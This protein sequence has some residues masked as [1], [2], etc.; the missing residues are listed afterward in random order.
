MK[1]STREEKPGNPDYS[2]SGRST[3][4]NPKQYPNY[5]KIFGYVVVGIV[6]GILIIKGFVC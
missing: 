1:K 2:G 4:S 6:L 3:P 5:L